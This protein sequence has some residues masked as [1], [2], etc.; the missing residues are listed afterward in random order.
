MPGMD[1]QLW[2]PQ[3]AQISLQLIRAMELQCPPAS[4]IQVVPQM[5]HQVRPLKDR[6]LVGRYKMQ[7]KIINTNDKPVKHKISTGGILTL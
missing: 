3:S 1:R 6:E 7:I 4:I 2:Q 5:L